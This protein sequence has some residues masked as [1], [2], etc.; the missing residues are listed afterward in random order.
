MISLPDIPDIP[1]LPCG[2]DNDIV[3]WYC[4]RP[5]YSRSS[6]LGFFPPPLRQK[7]QPGPSP[8]LSRSSSQSEHENYENEED[9]ENYENEE[10]DNDKTTHIAAT[11]AKTA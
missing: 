4:G 3:T 6:S 2:F 9:E 8:G 10:A 7:T 11:E 5:S 1:D